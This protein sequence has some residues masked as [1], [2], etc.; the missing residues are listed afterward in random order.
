MASLPFLPVR[1]FNVFADGLNVG[2]PITAAQIPFPPES[3][4]DV[5]FGGVVGAFAVM[6]STDA[7]EVP[8]NTKG[9]QP[10]LLAQFMA[11]AGVRKTYTVMA[12]LIDELA[13]GATKQPIPVVA[14]II[15]RLSPAIDKLEGGALTGT[16]YT[17][18]SVLKYS[19]TIGGRE[20]ARYDLQLGGWLDQAGVQASIAAAIGFNV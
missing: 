19:C 12:A 20:V 16:E 9:I 8:F 18:K 6:T 3:G 10:D 1:G 11:G 13:S 4:E 15:G 17:I 5:N 2:L 7:I 14:T